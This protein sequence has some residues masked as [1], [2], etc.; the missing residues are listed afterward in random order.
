LELEK[1]K[2]LHEK[3]SQIEK[4]VHENDSSQ[5]TLKDLDFLKKEEIAE[6]LAQIENLEKAL[7]DKGWS[8]GDDIGDGGIAFKKIS[9]HNTKESIER[10]VLSLSEGLK[11]DLLDKIDRLES[12]NAKVTELHKEIVGK[13]EKVQSEKSELTQKVLNLDKALKNLAKSSIPEKIS[14]GKPP[15]VSAEKK[16][17]NSEIDGLKKEIDTLRVSL[18]NLESVKQKEMLERD[19]QISI[20]NEEISKLQKS[21]KGNPGKAELDAS[22]KENERLKKEVGKEK[23][24][25]KKISTQESEEKKLRASLKDLSEKLEKILAEKAKEEK[26]KKDLSEKTKKLEGFVKILEKE[27][28]DGAAMIKKIKSEQA[29]MKKTENEMG[30]KLKILEKLEGESQIG[31]TKK[32]EELKNLTAAKFVV[33]VN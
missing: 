3:D 24:L 25:L 4:L 33:D 21:L 22:K 14:E 9:D 23:E 31:L 11:R 30:E 2:I 20:K 32:T 28:L 29:I 8:H 13:H 10:S 5:K 17:G 1:T 27:K 12:D 16:R 18:K 15:P 19:R 26:L 7:R 6:L